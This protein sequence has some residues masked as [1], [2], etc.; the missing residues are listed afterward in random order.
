MSEEQGNPAVEETT[1][2]EGSLS[3]SEIR[4]HDLFKNVVREKDAKLQAALAELNEI[5]SKREAEAKAKEIAAKEEQGQFA[6][7]KAQLIAEN[8]RIKSEYESRMT[9]LK[10]ET[11][12]ARE[13]ADEYFTTWA[14]SNYES[15][16]DVSEYVDALKADEKHSMRFNLNQ[17]AEPGNPPPSGAMPAARSPGNWAQTKQDLS[18]RDPSIREAADQRVRA[19]MEKHGKLPW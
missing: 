2:E 12:L 11:A 18:S 10:L 6:E 16:V 7:V 19:H 1:P 9:Q 8:E 3:P 17:I 13:G 5:K 15:G 4:N 14:I